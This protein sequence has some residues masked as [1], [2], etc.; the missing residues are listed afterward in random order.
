MSDSL[1]AQASSPARLE[2]GRS[3]RKAGEDACAPS[4]ACAY[5][6]LDEAARRLFHT[7]WS[8]PPKQD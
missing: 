2:G 5:Y 3:A 7:K 1:G 8:L 6:S 4:V